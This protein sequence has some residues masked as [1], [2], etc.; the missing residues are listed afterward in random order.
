MSTYKNRSQV[1]RGKAFICD[2]TIAIREAQIQAEIQIVS[3][4]QERGSEF[5]WEK[6]RKTR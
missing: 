4:I 3:P 5:L 2:E 6:G 1:L